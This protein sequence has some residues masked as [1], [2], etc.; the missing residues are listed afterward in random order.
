MRK[1]FPNG[2]DPGELRPGHDED[3]H[4]PRK[5]RSADVVFWLVVGA[6]AILGAVGLTGVLWLVLR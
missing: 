2:V 4:L 3:L 5:D 6:A 1:Q